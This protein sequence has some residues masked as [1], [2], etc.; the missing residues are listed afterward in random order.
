M[1]YGPKPDLTHPV[2]QPEEISSIDAAAALE[3]SISRF[4]KEPSTSFTDML[5]GVLTS[6]RSSDPCFLGKN[7]PTDMIIH[8]LA[9]ETAKNMVR[10]YQIERMA[11]VYPLA[12][13]R[14]TLAQGPCAQ[15]RTLHGTLYASD[16]ERPKLP[17]SGCRVLDCACRYRLMTMRQAELQGQL[18]ADD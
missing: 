13:F 2:E 12:Q 16:A 4:G 5:D 7:R 11:S 3:W 8:R 14:C 1:T 17:L 18:K 10:D 6:L 9:V 15:A